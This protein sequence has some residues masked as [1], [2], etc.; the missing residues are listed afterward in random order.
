[1]S[2]ELRAIRITSRLSIPEDEL[3]FTAS[4]SSGPGG[5][6]V[7]KVSTRVTLWFDVVNSPSLSDEQKQLLLS[8]LPNHINKEGMLWVVSQQTRSQ[9]LN[10]EAATERF[11]E[12]LHDVLK[13]LKPRKETRISK[14][15]KL[16]R[17][18]EK[19]RRGTQKRERS[20]KPFIED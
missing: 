5:Q 15:S 18:D 12:M 7:N 3:K 19:K 4:R 20:G 8:R 2:D 11:A 9:A 10:R 1:M 14:A 17:L 16:R 6:N 13:P